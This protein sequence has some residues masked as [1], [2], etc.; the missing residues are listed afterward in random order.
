MSR[1]SDTRRKVTRFYRGARRHPNWNLGDPPGDPRQRDRRSWEGRLGLSAA[2]LVL[3]F[4]IL[5]SVGD[6]ING[7]RTGTNGCRILVVVDGD[8]LQI[9]CPGRG[10]Q[11]ARI[12]GFDTPELK[13]RCA[14]EFFKAIAAKQY[15]RMQIWSASEVSA[16]R[17][18]TD[19]YDRALVRLFVDGVSVAPAMISSGFA[20]PYEGGRRSGWCGATPTKYG[21]MDV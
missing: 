8:T 13:A 1:R 15:L 12:I 20:R 10:R 9:S 4:S 18:G 11:S 2:G 7:W 5:P 6:A 21:D 19:R 3:A 14:S 17:Q 16:V